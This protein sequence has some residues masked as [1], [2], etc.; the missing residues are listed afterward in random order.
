MKE[1]ER[2]FSDAPIGKKYFV[3]GAMWADANPEKE[4]DE[5]LMAGYETTLANMNKLK[6][7][8]A[9][10]KAELEKASAAKKSAA[11]KPK[12]KADADSAPEA[13]TAS[14]VLVD[15]EQMD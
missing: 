15:S 7:Q 3:A 1:A 5:S 13:E 4:Y 14:P 2:R 6:E 8:I 9:G 12:K 11:R 10:L